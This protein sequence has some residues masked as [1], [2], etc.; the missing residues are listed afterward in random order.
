M[1]APGAPDPI[2]RFAEHVAT[3]RFEHLSPH[4]VRALK[5]FVLDTLG[6]GVAGTGEA[7]APRL[8]QCARAWGRADESAVWG[9]STRLPGP[10]AALVNAYQ[11]HC[12]EF[13]CVHE[14]AVVHPMATALSAAMAH[15]ER[16][17]PV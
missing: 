2:T 13:D 3:T 7:W 10:S 1:H 14:G 6:V 5:T 12:M 8:L 15:A 16:G 9:T 17:A 11:I 4:A